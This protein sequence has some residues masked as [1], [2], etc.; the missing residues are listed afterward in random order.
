MLAY[1]HTLGGV[2]V[3][4]KKLEIDVDVLIK[5]YKERRNLREVANILGVSHMTVKRR[6]EE[7]GLDRIKWG[8]SPD[9]VKRP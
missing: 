9:W 4:R 7:H 2:A 6:M 3:G 8:D 1:G 5:L